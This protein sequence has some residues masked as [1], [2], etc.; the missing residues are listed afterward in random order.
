MP[1]RLPDDRTPEQIG[2]KVA[3]VLWNHFEQQGGGGT[4]LIQPAAS[5]ATQAYDDAYADTLLA[6]TVVAPAVVAPAVVSAP[7]T[8]TQIVT[9]PSVPERQRPKFQ[10][11]ERFRVPI[12]PAMSV[13]IPVR[14]P[15]S[16]PPVTAP[17]EATPP[18]SASAE[19]AP[20]LDATIAPVEQPPA[21]AGRHVQ[22]A[23]AVV[24]PPRINVVQLGFL[25]GSTVDLA[26]DHP[27][28][29]ALRA[30]ALALTVHS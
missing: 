16:A 17:Q 23:L 14:L 28:A 6:E 8:F 24:P 29:K 25:D 27:A 10:I 21:P 2:G 15:A 9:R 5:V 1:A 18:E 13:T 22:T 4:P 19:I 11:Y 30:A 26:S 3:E 12:A 7:A 20:L